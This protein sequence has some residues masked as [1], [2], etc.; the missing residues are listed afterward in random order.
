MKM[1][2]EKKMP[3]ANDYIAACNASR[4]KANDMKQTYTDLA[5]WCAKAAR[6]RSYI[7]PVSVDFLWVEENGRR[8]PDNIAFAKKFIMDGLVRAN[9]LRDDSM[10]FV[11]GFSDSFDVDRE[12]PRIEV[13]VTE[14]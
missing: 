13:T 5:A 14:I 8:D 9:V 4:F 7:G 6:M 3:G 10:R 12:N 2:V 11:R 1:I